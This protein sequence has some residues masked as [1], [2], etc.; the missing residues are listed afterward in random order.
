MHRVFNCDVFAA[1]QLCSDLS[2]GPIIDQFLIRGA[3][4]EDGNINLFK[5]VRL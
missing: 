2:M 5:N 3:G 4:D 1:A